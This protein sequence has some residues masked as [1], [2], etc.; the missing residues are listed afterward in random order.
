MRFLKTFQKRAC[1]KQL[2][3]CKWEQDC[4]HFASFLFLPGSP[5][6]LSGFVSTSRFPW[7]GI[8][9]TWGG[10]SC[11]SCWGR[12]MTENSLPLNTCLGNAA[13]WE[14]SIYPG[15][16]GWVHR[17]EQ[18]RAPTVRGSPAGEAGGRRGEGNRSRGEQT[19][20]WLEERGVGVGMNQ[21][22]PQEQRSVQ[23]KNPGGSVEAGGSQERWN[24]LD[25]I[26]PALKQGMG[27]EIG[28]LK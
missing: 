7:G 14:A 8:P 2:F 17:G 13:G 3:S 25:F 12:A 16:M 21:P 24:D 6:E 1:L 15:M 27:L 26:S 28:S 10:G 18:H 22:F 11:S 5:Q 4:H 23:W 19:G 9:G 20:W